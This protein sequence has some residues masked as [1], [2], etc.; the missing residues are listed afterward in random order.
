[1]Y[2]A[3]ESIEGHV[4]PGADVFVLGAILYE[5]ASGEPLFK[6]RRAASG[7]GL[8]KGLERRL[9]SAGIPDGHDLAIPRFGSVLRRCL[10]LDRAQRFSSPGQVGQAL[11]VVQKEG[12]LS[13][14]DL[15]TFLLTVASVTLDG[16]LQVDLSARG[17]DLAI[18]HE[19]EWS[20][21][22]VP[23]VSPQPRKLN[24]QG[25]AGDALVHGDAHDDDEGEPWTVTD[26]TGEM[27]DMIRARMEQTRLTPVKRTGTFEPVEEPDETFGQAVKWFVKRVLLFALFLVVMVF[28]IAYLGF[29]PGGTERLAARGFDALPPAVGDAIPE[30]WVDGT[31][32]WWADRP[33]QDIGTEWGA[34]ILPRLPAELAIELAPEAPT[35][36]LTSGDL[37][38]EGVA[39]SGEGWIEPEAELG[40]QGRLKL[41]V[42]FGGRP[43]GDRVTVSA[44]RADDAEVVAEGPA[45]QALRLP[46]G[47][48]D[49]ELTYQESE[50]TEVRPGWVRGV[51]VTA[52]YQSSYLVKLDAPMGFVAVQIKTVAGTEDEEVAEG[53]DSN[54]A[55]RTM[56]LEGWREPAGEDPSGTP[57]FS[58]SVVG[59]VGLDVGRWR[60]KATLFEE[61]RADAVAWFRNVHVEKAE[62]I[63]LVRDRLRRGE[64]LEPEGPGIRIAAT[65]GGRDVSEHV[66]VMVFSPGDKPAS[67]VPLASG[68]AAYYFR[69]QEGTWDVYTVYVP[70]PEDPSLRV[71]QR[72]TITLEAGQVVRQT[73]EMGLPIALVGAE[74]WDGDE[75]LTEGLRLL[76]L[77]AGA[78]FEG[79][80]RVADERGRGPHPVP[81][82]LYD[83]YFQAELE[84]GL[85]TAKFA[86]VTL[87]AGDVWK[88]RLE[89]SEVEWSQ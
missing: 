20:M 4:G 87:V 23:A 2:K 38:F 79:A 40:G 7:D 61:G 64:V 69:V 21:P 55:P 19:D 12:G 89:Q 49:L 29:F 81:P 45:D 14:D 22:E 5:M 17:L 65:N 85:R 56:R 63:T 28:A 51:V 57:D 34:K 66:R 35:P 27:D 39:A 88:R 60:L 82:G 80:T 31:K 58:G 77:R 9:T 47:R 32:S 25:S 41:S 36:P 6:G 13:D 76:V 16:P 52:G 54:D 75:E 33:G 73:V 24:L 50:H 46:E 44:H 18:A 48:Y 26:V 72:V 59:I 10:Q 74:L 37:T 70:N 11:R 30:A 71:Q 8:T 43:R 1:V 53:S 15:D 78:S 67:A 86:D 42:D 62:T 84:V 3:P 83:V 68:P